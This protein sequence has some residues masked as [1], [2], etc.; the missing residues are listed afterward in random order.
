MDGLTC[1]HIITEDILII[2]HGKAFQEAN[3][4]HDKNMKAFLQSV[5]MKISLNK[6]KFHYMLESI[7]F[8]GQVFTSS[9]LKSDPAKVRAIL[10]MPTS[11]ADVQRLIGMVN[12]LA[13]FV[14][15]LSDMTEPLRKLTH[16]HHR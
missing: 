4:D 6:D 1:I 16:K 2:G 9:G 7:N 13:K 12:Y 8:I 10:N 11:P 15:H 5:A 14:P 3:A